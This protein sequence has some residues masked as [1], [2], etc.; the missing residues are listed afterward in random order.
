MLFLLILFLRRVG[1]AGRSGRYLFVIA[2]ST[3]ILNYGKIQILRV[4]EVTPSLL[5]GYR[6][7]KIVVKINFMRRRSIPILSSWLLGMFLLIKG[8]R[9]RNLRFTEIENV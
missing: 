1:L 8:S 9:L 2:Y 7:Y 6:T 5:R 4:V 3:E